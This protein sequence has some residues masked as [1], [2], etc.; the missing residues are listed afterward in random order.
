[1]QNFLKFIGSTSEDSNPALLSLSALRLIENALDDIDEIYD[2]HTHLGGSEQN[3]TGCCIHP[4]LN[5][6]F[7]PF[8]FGQQIVFKSSA[9]INNNKGGDKEYLDKLIS[10][11][12]NFSYCVNKNGNLPIYRH[13]LLALAKWYDPDGT[14]RMDKTSMYIPN[15]YLMDVVE[16]HS[17]IFDPC[18]SINPYQPNALD[19]LKFYAKKGVRIVKWLPNS[20]G[21]KMDD[22]NITPFYNKMKKYNMI[23]LCHVGD[24]H[25]MSSGG[26]NQELGNPLHLKAPLDCGIKTIAAHC[27]S[28]GNNSDLEDPKFTKVSNFRLLLRLMDTPKYKD[29]LFADISSMLLVTRIGDPLTTILDRNDL[30]DNLVF[31]SDYP[32]P[33]I[34]LISRTDKLKSYG[35]I[36]E[37]ERVLLNEIFYCNPLLYDFVAKRVIRSP[38]TGNQFPKSVFEKNMR[39]LG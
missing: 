2:M 27:A 26:T 38:N 34:G 11:T 18:V 39:L 8:S 30:H 1:M 6:I 15:D 22:P 16:K 35:Y 29:L 32:V 4:N 13:V 20:M 3:V 37:K 21:I 23:L 25:A 7:H 12:Q 5:S 17:D 19:E 14:E 10:R 33:T 28:E 24:E 9:G 36:N 31:G